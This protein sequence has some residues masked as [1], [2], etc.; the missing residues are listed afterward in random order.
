MCDTLRA[1][2]LMHNPYPVVACPYPATLPAQLTPAKSQTRTLTHVFPESSKH[3]R[4]NPATRPY[5]RHYTHAG[6]TYT[7]ATHGPYT[8]LPTSP[9][10]T[11]G[12]AVPV[13]LRATHTGKRYRLRALYSLRATHGPHGDTGHTARPGTRANPLARYPPNTRLSPKSPLAR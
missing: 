2:Y 5:R 1:Q 13:S 3:L 4:R 7:R 11:H 6:H 9:T 10:H 8:A 12:L